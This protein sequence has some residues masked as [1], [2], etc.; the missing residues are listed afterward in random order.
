LKVA[1]KKDGVSTE[2]TSHHSYTD[3]A[4]KFFGGNGLNNIKTFH[5]VDGVLKAITATDG[6]KY[7]IKLAGDQIDVE[8]AAKNF[9]EISTN[10]CGLNASDWEFKMSKK[11][12]GT[13]QFTDFDNKTQQFAKVKYLHIRRKGDVNRGGSFKKLDNGNFV[14]SAANENGWFEVRRHEIAGNAPG[15]VKDKWLDFTI[16]GGKII[17]RPLIDEVFEGA[18][19][20]LKS[21]IRDQLKQMSDAPP[22]PSNLENIAEINLNDVTQKDFELICE[23]LPSLGDLRLRSD[24]ITAIPAKFKNLKLNIIWLSGNSIPE[25]SEM[26]LDKMERFRVGAISPNLLAQIKTKTKITH[27]GTS[28]KIKIDEDWDGK[29]FWI[30][31]HHWEEAKDNFGKIYK[32]YEIKDDT[33]PD[34]LDF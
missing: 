21:A 2:V 16:E 25:I 3:R 14:F 5:V 17:E 26:N 23:K 22:T 7:G 6:K 29:K 11:E 20:K 33:H 15:S 12:S 19:T 31:D 34:T 10:D 24:K 18:S 32:N 8:V 27:V 13:K 4:K 1:L 28:S 9:E 30:K